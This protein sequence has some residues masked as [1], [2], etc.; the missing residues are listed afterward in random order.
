[1]Q[2]V[3]C[4]CCSFWSNIGQAF[5]MPHLK[6]SFISFYACHINWFFFLDNVMIFNK[7]NP[8]SLP[9][10]PNSCPCA[11]HGTFLFLVLQPLLSRHCISRE[12][13]MRNTRVWVE[14]VTPLLTAIAWS[15]CHWVPG[16]LQETTG[17]AKPRSHSPKERPSWE[18]RPWE[19]SRGLRAEATGAHSQ[20]A[21]VGELLV[22]EGAV[23]SPTPENR[24]YPLANTNRHS[25]RQTCILPEA[26]PRKSNLPRCHLCKNSAVTCNVV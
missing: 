10:L 5:N 21:G 23:G 24:P 14:V 11:W 2:W 12:I 17:G 16:I 26:V 8:T 20:A 9:L 22:Q 7:N 6:G 4:H 25:L 19:W 18:C 15:E 1:M 3:Q 13:P